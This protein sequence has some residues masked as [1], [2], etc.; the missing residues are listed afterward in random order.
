VKKP[1]VKPI[2]N[3]IMAKPAA[4]NKANNNKK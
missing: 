1:E 2:Q 3:N 4:I